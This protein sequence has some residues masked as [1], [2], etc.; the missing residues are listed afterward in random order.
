MLIKIGLRQNLLYPC[1]FILFLILRQ[2]AKSIIEIIIK[3]FVNDKITINYTMLTI[4]Y[5]FQLIMGIITLLFLYLKKTDKP[6]NE[7]KQEKRKGLLL[8]QNKE[9]LESPDSVIKIFILIFFAAFFE[10]VGAL[11]RRFFKGNVE[12]VDTYDEYHAKFRCIEL[13]FASILCFFIFQIKILMHQLFSL[14][15]I[16][17][18]LIIVLTIDIVNERDILK[19]IGNII[20]SSFCRVYLDIIEKYLFDYDFLDLYQLMAYEGIINIILDSILYI[21]ENPR[22]EIK[23]IVKMDNIYIFLTFFFIFIYAILSWFKNIYR[24]FTIKQ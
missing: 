14:L 9:Q 15:I 5:L 11:T 18:C 10:I 8:I 22:R 24:R 12:T 13:C 19:N 16:L 7:E 20:I 17:I 2:I 6:T 21:S 4:L 3:K 23:N 1:F